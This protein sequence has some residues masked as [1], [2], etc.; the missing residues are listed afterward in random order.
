MFVLQFNYI[1]RSEVEL[2]NIINGCVVS[3]SIAPHF[4]FMEQEIWLPID[5]FN[6]KY[7]VSSL[8]RIRSNYWLSK[9]GK[10][11][12]TNIILKTTVN[13][14][15]YEAV[16]LSY[17][18]KIEKTFKVHRL[19]CT[20][21]HENPENKPQ[22][23]HKD[24]N[25]LNNHKDNLEWV[26]PK[27]NVKH[28]IE[29]GRIIK[30]KTIQIPLSIVKYGLMNKN[31]LT[32]SDIAEKYNLPYHW[33]QKI[34]KGRLKPKTPKKPEIIWAKRVINIYSG[35]E[36]RSIK[37]VHQIYGGSLRSL[38]KKLCGSKRNNTPYRY[39]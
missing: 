14:M 17:G 21:F 23:N 29:N 34:F 37:E 19:V 5:G 31:T 7:D 8:G 3:D 18:K 22:V 36:Y 26:T 35:V 38:Y 11:V 12:T 20:V 39:L 1:C 33:V 16:K 27:E 2:F 13:S 25:K 6:S 15:G 28:A 30:N 32:I 4:Y 10:M 24:C 9:N